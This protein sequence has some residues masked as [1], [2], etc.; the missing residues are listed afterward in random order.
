MRRRIHLHL[1]PFVLFIWVSACGETRSTTSQTEGSSDRPTV[2]DLQP[3]VGR[4][5]TV[6]GR[7]NGDSLRLLF[8]SGGGETLLA[9][10]V[11]EAIPCV[12]AG[13]SVGFRMSGERVEWPLC[14]GVRLNLA[15]QTVVDSVAGI[16][17]VMAIL[18]EGLP[19]LDGI[20]SL[21]TFRDRLLILHLAE[22]R[23]ELHSEGTF[24]E[25]VGTMI[26]APMRVATGNDGSHLTVFLQ[27]RLVDT[28]QSAW[29][30]LDSGN[31]AETL[32]APHV[33]NDEATSDATIVFSDSLAVTAPARTADIIY[34]GALS[35]AFL[36]QII[37]ALD[38]ERG[39]AWVAPAS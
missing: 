23:L 36:R 37:V 17:D 39:Q 33:R 9:P 20:I 7:L 34:D 1:L 26:P 12:P 15:G 32:L 21:E 3:Y 27:G 38:L 24:R 2:L 8:D 30:L 13:R 4:L 28:D 14:H 5:V 25:R 18:P 31:L 16:W 19:R 35:E 22:S 29:L 11:A 10:W 6:T